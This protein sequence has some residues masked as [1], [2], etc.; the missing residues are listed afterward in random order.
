MLIVK[1]VILCF[2]RFCYIIIKQQYLNYLRELFNVAMLL[3]VDDND[4]R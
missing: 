2:V 4:K 1:A 3:V